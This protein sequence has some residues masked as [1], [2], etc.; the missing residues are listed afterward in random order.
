VRTAVVAFVTEAIVYGMPWMR[1]FLPTSAGEENAAVADVTVVLPCVALRS[2]PPRMKPKHGEPDCVGP[3]GV[4]VVVS[5]PLRTMFVETTSPAEDCTVSI[6]LLIVSVSFA[7]STTFRTVKLH[8]YGWPI[9][10]GLS[11][12]FV[13]PIPCWTLSLRTANATL[14]PKN[15]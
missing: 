3:V 4:V 10:V 7:S 2:E 5:W 15:V 13:N 12:P 14:M 6:R 9:A 8:E 1:S 11:Q